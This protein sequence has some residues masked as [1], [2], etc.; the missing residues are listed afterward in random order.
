MANA[1]VF[2]IV[3]WRFT[4]HFLL[5]FVQTAYSFLYFITE[6]AF[7]HGLNPH[8]YVTYRYFLGGSLVLPFAYFLERKARPKMT[9]PLFL[10]IF[11]LSLLG[12]EVVDVRNPRGIAKI[13]GTL[14]A[15]G[16][17][18]ILA[19]Y[20]GTDMQSSH[21]AP[22]HVRSNPAQQK[23]IKG[24]FLLAASCITWSM[25]AIMQVYTLKKYPAQLSLT[26]M[27]NFLGGAQSAVFALCT[28]HKPEAWYIKFD[29]NFWCIVYAGIVVCALTVFLQLWCTKQKGPVFVTMFNPLST[30]EVA[31]LAYFFFGEKLRSGSLLGGAVVI[32]G[33]YLVLLGKE[34]DQD[35]MKSQEQSSPS[36]GEEKDSHVQIEASAR[37]ES[38]AAG[39]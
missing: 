14:M 37:R 9:L 8:V 34:G 2:K 21:D 15:L 5:F 29:I 17:A 26:A 38:W 1:Y 33:L 27:I 30:V 16:G 7:S 20:K 39:S 32:V 31:I 10:E 35:Q 19:F 28:Q 36:N 22:I 4:P 25:W 24:S 3:N 6:A 18:L 11:V 23:W 12:L 13:L